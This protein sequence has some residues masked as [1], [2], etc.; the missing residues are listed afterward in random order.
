MDHHFSSR[1]Q[2]LRVD[3]RSRRTSTRDTIVGIR[4]VTGGSGDDRLTGDAADNRLS[5]GPGDDV[6]ADDVGDDIPIGGSGDDRLSGGAGKDYLIGEAGTDRLDGGPGD[7]VFDTKEVD[8]DGG[9]GTP[10]RPDE[11]ACGDGADTA[12]SDATDTLELA[13]EQLEAEAYGGEI[14][15]GT[16]PALRGDHADFTAT[17]AGLQA[18]VGTLSLSGVPLNS[19]AV[20]ALHAGTTVQVNTVPDH[21][22]SSGYRMF[23]R[24]G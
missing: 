22:R 6:V 4:N 20:A 21:F 10:N 3:L 15:L 5:G 9:H 24:A 14:V 11:V 18:A 23:L 1:Q 13:C 19:V 7:D 2:S 8:D 17:F 16:I 12:R